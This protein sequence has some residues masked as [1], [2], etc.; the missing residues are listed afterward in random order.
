MS[1]EKIEQAFRDHVGKHGVRGRAM[2]TLDGVRALLAELFRL[3][4]VERRA[5]EVIR[6]FAVGCS[7]HFNDW[8]PDEIPAWYDE[9]DEPGAEFK[10]AVTVGDFREA[11][12]FYRALPEREG[13]E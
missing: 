13:Q 12:D 11:R 1:I 8:C 6:P 7:A 9:G 10:S 3:R 4:E 2:F 5:K